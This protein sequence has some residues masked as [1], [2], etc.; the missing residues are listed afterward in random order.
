MPLIRYDIGD[1]AEVGPPSPCG[2][3]LPVLTRIQGRTRAM[4]TLPDGGRFWPFI[5]LE[6]LL[7]AAPVRQFQ[8]VQKSLSRIE[9]R[10]AV[11]R[12]LSADQQARLADIVRDSLHHP[13][14]VEVISVDAIL[15]SEITS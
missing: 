2:R 9:L 7:D 14:N 15:R 13:F 11:D 5:R 4:V 12:P 6:D 10:L 3:S 1:W 8:V